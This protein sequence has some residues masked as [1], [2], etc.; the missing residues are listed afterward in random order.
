M[1]EFVFIPLDIFY[2]KLYN[3]GIATLLDAWL[4]FLGVSD[5]EWIEKLIRRYLEFIPLY[6]EVYAICT[7]MERVM[8]IFSEELKMLDKNIVQPT[9]WIWIVIIGIALVLFLVACLCLQAVFG[10]RCEGNP[11]LKYLTEKD[12]DGLEAEPISFVSDRG[13]R[14]CGAVYTCRG[15][16]NPSCLVVFAH[17]M[18]GGH[19][20]YTTMIHGLA[21][22]GF[23][24]LA[25][26]NTGTMSSGG[27]ALG[28]FYQAVLDLRSAL[29]FVREDEKLSGYK[30]VLAGH[31]WGCYAVCQ[32]LAFE[33]TNVSGAV[34]FSP[35][36]AIPRVICDGM[37]QMIGVPVSWLLPVFWVASVV[38]SG[39]DS[40]RKSSSVLLGTETVPVLILHGS[41]DKT[42]PLSN[43]PLSDPRVSEKENITCIL[44]DG[45]AH[46]VYQTKE[47]EQYLNE[48]FDAIAKAE[49][50]Y[51]RKIP[52]EKKA[53]LYDIDY[54][55]ITK[56][57]L[58]VIKTVVDFIKKCVVKS[59]KKTL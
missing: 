6:E 42:V 34:A 47:A 9:L 51:G 32:S 56:E 13:Q 28:S 49:H 35:P 22:A 20:S 2:K 17:G 3:K 50:Q 36:N 27:K 37:R 33:E 41:A 48:V 7:N 16:D 19:L 57:D 14:L 44:Y 31:S 12:F 4:V 10:V 43:S 39:W 53:Q 54:E 11:D 55:L 21:K 52:S 40:R 5:P 45:R 29:A 1:Q 18:G 46:N 58:D 26:D 38:R 23:A 30:V 25:Y 24:V 59:M 8:G 15:V